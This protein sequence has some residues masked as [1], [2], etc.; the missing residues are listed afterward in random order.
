MRITRDDYKNIWRHAKE[1]TS[2]CSKYG[3]HFGHYFVI[4]QDDELTDFHTMMINITLMSG[5][6]PT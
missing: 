2:S 1:Q 5:Y 6:S 3:L 4:I